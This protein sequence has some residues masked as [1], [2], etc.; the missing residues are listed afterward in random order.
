M[1]RRILKIGAALAF[2][3][4]LS[5]TTFSADKIDSLIKEVPGVNKYP[6]A[7]IINVFTEVEIQ[8]NNNQSSQIHVFK[9]IKILNYKGKKDYSD[10]K[11]TYHGEYDKIELGT[12]LSI[13]PRGKR[14]PVPENQ[15]YDLDTQQS[16]MN[17]LIN[18]RQRILNFPQIEPGYFIVLEFTLTSSWTEPFNR[19]EHF[20][21][22]N[23]ILHKKVSL[24]FP[25]KFKLNYY[26]DHNRLVFA[27]KSMANHHLYTWEIKNSK[28]I[29]QENNT[30]VFLISGIPLVF[31][32]YKNWSDFVQDKFSDFIN[33]KVDDSVKN[34]AK[35]ITK[36]C[37]DDQE[38]L[39]AIYKYFCKNFNYQYAIGYKMNLAPRPLGQILKDKKGPQ[40]D[41]L[42]LFIAMAKSV[43]IK[44]IYPALTISN[45][46]RFPETQQEIAVYDLMGK[47]C[48]FWNDKL[49][50]VGINYMPFGY[51]TK[52]TRVII[53]G[54]ELKW[55]DFKNDD[56]P[57]EQNF[58]TYDL[59][60]QS[61]MVSVKSIYTKNLNMRFRS[62]FQDQPQ[63]RRKIWFNQTLGEKSANLVDGPD[64][65]NFDKI[66]E[67][68]ILEYKLEYN[69]FM[70]RQSPY[71][72]F[73]IYPIRTPHNVAIQN[74][75]NDYQIYNKTYKRES[76]VINLDKKMDFINPIQSKKFEFAIDNNRAYFLLNSK[77]RGDQIFISREIFIPEGIINRENYREFKEFILKIKDPI[78][79][80][81]FLQKKT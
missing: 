19:T 32:F 38:K 30:P 57:M 47:F 14:I 13:D 67:D 44:D 10:I 76:F 55:I 69:D 66:E 41:L 28:M 40:K 46:S 58:Y 9:I 59:N 42:P 22:S 77:K 45:Y 63:V 54:K 75:E 6:D 39:L 23:P 65:K 68:L 20:R 26:F 62:A 49:F 53:G 81:I 11:I 70:V 12:C 64:F 18:F 60:E 36:G 15:I 80:M 29:K 74:R 21:S 25:K 1:T 31:S 16:I 35:K 71:F 78:H 56:E 73:K 34:L 50:T 52:D 72:Y 33:V 24:K 61:A 17:P 51:A 27:K 8:I 79:N 43:G 48:T 2:L 5:S 37:T 4:Y 3:F 7:S